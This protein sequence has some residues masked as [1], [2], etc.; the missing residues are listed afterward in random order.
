MKKAMIS[1][2]TK[3]SKN[4]CLGKIIR[5]QGENPFIEYSSY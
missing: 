5:K 3:H 2:F 4:K 1:S